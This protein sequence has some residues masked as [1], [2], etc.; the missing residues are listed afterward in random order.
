MCFGGGDNTVANTNEHPAGY[1]L[2]DSASQVQVQTGADTSPPL[3]PAPA[4][5]P[6]KIDL[7]GNAVSKTTGLNT[8]GM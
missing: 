8:I 7:T 6:P 2:G 3:T 1:A 5:A 4:A